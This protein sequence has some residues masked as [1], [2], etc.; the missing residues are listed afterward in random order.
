MSSVTLPS[1][2]IPSSPSNSISSTTTA[3]QQLAGTR[4]LFKPLALGVGSFFGGFTAGFILIGMNHWQ[5]GAASNKLECVLLGCCG[6]A[7]QLMLMAIANY[8]DPLASVIS[9]A[10]PF[11]IGFGYH[12]D[13]EHLTRGASKIESRSP[14]L[15]A[16]IGIGCFA[17]NIIAAL[18]IFVLIGALSFLL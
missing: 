3:T 5:K 16:A 18:G 14:W 2:S 6:L 7:M 11:I 8:I 13:R 4:R 17:L 1:K 10:I 9:L 15:A 12:A